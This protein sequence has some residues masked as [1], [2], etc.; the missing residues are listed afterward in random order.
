MINATETAALI[1]SLKQIK[2]EANSRYTWDDKGFA[3]LFSELH[4]D[5]CR[6][7]ATAREWFCYDGKV[8]ALDPSGMQ[9]SQLAKQL[10]DAL[11]QYC[12]GISDEQL[13]T[14]Y[15]K[16][17]SVYG[18]LR[19]REN[20][21]RDA[22]D[23][24]FIKQTDLDENLNLLNLQNGVFD[25][26]TGAFRAHSPHDLLS[27]IANADYKPEARCDR[28]ERFIDEVMCGD[29]AKARYLQKILGY[30]MTAETSLE[31]C[32][33]LYG[34]TTRNGKS[35]LCETVM[36]LMGNYALSMRPETLAQKQNKD[37]RTATG[38]IARL[39][40]C[41]FLNA[42]EPP[43]RMLLDSALLKG[44][45]GRDTIT[46]RH[47]YQSEFQFIPRF[48]LMMN[49]NYLPMITDDS[50]FSSGRVVVIPFDRHFRNEEQDKGLKDELAAPY[51]LSG[52]LNWMLEGL[53][54]FRVEGAELPDSLIMATDEYRQSSDKFGLFME[55]CLV[56]T[57]NNSAAGK[58]YER[59]AEWCSDYGYGVESKGSFFDELK[60]R[61]I[62]AS[63]GT[64]GGKTLHNILAGYETI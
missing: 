46:A 6:Y 36:H 16:K 42:S 12:L 52:I 54:L 44:L 30:S 31:C 17:V 29:V 38:D 41:R 51:N 34:S 63:S 23:C 57:G 40:G 59:Y 58:V 26:S 49:T 20:L 53:R 11:V 64:V 21:I 7:N 15:L 55:E 1:E 61:G 43:R 48:K 22:R 14:A 9:T 60:R 45:L 33:I 62:Y 32:W 28:W 27:K 56:K 10:A 47:L 2:P 50:I 19:Y 8:W 3:E 35:T 39:D 37:S 13:K 24:N 4:R 5:R 25:L 18:Q